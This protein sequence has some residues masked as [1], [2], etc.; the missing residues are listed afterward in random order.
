MLHRGGLGNGLGDGIGLGVAAPTSSGNTESETDPKDP[1]E[2]PPKG[3]SS[4]TNVEAAMAGQ[5][6]ARWDEKRRVV[7]AHGGAKRSVESARGAQADSVFVVTGQ[8]QLV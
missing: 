5:D 4:S 1:W 8:K 7:A 6:R 2:S 3:P